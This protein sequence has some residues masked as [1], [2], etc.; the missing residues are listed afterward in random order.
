MPNSIKVEWDITSE[1]VGNQE[2]NHSCFTVTQINL[3]ETTKEIW[4]ITYTYNW[5]CEDGCC[6]ETK[7]GVAYVNSISE[8]L[9][10]RLLEKLPD[11]KL[12][13]IR[14]ND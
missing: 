12:Q 8:Y 6:S 7:T 11:Y 2:G 13:A 3:N 10:Q 1:D 14:W 5:G 9:R 4:S